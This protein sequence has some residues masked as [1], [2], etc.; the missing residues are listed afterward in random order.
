MAKWNIRIYKV[1]NDYSL[2]QI[3]A[4]PDISEENALS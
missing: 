2:F 4:I 1:Y 3:Q